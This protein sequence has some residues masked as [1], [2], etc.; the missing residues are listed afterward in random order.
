[1]T[2]TQ[3]PLLPLIVDLREFAAYLRESG[4]MNWEADNIVEAADFLEKWGKAPEMLEAL[5][6]TAKWFAGKMEAEVDDVEIARH[7]RAIRAIIAEI[8]GK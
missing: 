1:M 5:R 7:H 4:P 2:T 3:T 8:E 6:D